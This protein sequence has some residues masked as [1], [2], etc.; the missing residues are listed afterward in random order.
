MSTPHFLFGAAR[1][2]TNAITWALESSDHISVKNE[3]SA[4]S[5]DQFLLKDKSAIEAVLKASAPKPAFFKCFHDTPRAR[6]LLGEYLNSRAIYAVRQPSDCIGSFVNEFGQAGA[7]IWMKRFVSAAR[8]RRGR[9]LYVCRDDPA[10]AD[11]AVDKAK[12]ILDVLSEFGASPDNI[13]ACYYLWAHSFADHIRLTEDRRFL[14]LDYDSM[15][16]DPQAALNRVCQHFS[17]AQINIDPERWFSGRQFGKN[18]D[19]A[20]Q[21]LALCEAGYK[22]ITA[23]L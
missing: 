12:F 6:Y 15:T 14:V 19:V 16:A 21:L 13:A 7:D 9:L 2:G 23:E 1:S 17:I 18:I 11:V 5:F 20:P 4:D 8:D 3:D 22:K 10:A